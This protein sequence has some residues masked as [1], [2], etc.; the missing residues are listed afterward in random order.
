M[1]HSGDLE[2][3]FLMFARFQQRNRERIQHAIDLLDEEPDFTLDE[4]FE[5]DREKAPWA[6]NQRRTRRNLAQAREERRACR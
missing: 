3:A 4:S 6:A 2:P 5:F 1:I